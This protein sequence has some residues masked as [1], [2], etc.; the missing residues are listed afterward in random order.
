[1]IIKLRNK[2]KSFKDE[3]EINEW[4]NTM[5][6]LYYISGGKEQ[7]KK[8]GQLQL[9]SNLVDIIEDK[10][11]YYAVMERVIG[12]DLFDYFV[13]EKIYEKDYKLKLAKK[14]ALIIS[15]SLYEL[16]SQG[17]IHKDLKLENIVCIFIQ[18]FGTQKHIVYMI[19][20]V[21]LFLL[22]RSVRFDAIMSSSIVYTG[23]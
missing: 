2:T 22:Q 21:F 18:S 14:M 20:N 5:K 11:N 6:L 19:V 17:L 23:Q 16:H 12:R 10:E 3:V 4:V 9:I 1:M 7:E 13:Q 8:P 15:Q